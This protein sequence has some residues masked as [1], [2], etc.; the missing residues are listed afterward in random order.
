M[1]LRALSCALLLFAGPSVAAP[2]DLEEALN[3]LKEAESKKDPAL[4]KKHAAETCALARKAIATLAPE[5]DDEKEAWTQRVAYARAVE[6][7]VE[8]ALYATAL[9]APA[10]A[11]VELLAALEEQ[12]PR[13]RYLDSGY[14][15]YF[16]A[17][18]KVG[19]ASKIPAIAEKAIVQF[20]ANEDLLLVAADSAMNRKQSD[21]ALGYAKQLVAVVGKHPRPEGMSAANWERK[22]TAALGRGYWIAGMVHAEKNQ[23]SPADQALRAA[24][25]LIQG[26]DLMTAGALF[27]LGVVNYQLGRLTNNKPQVLEAVKFSEKAAAITSPY[28]MQALRNAHVMRTEA[29]KMP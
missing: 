9:Q 15:H 25:P 6:L 10:A 22:K 4:V 17:L 5:S 7:Q 3:G 19:A 18:T 16:V 8:Y 21:R 13:S 1:L 12:N 24:L 20:P 11:A 23:Y 26:N 2:D 28:H 14:A 27:Y 29:F